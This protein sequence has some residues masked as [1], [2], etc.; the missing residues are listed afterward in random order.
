[1]KTD[2]QL[3]KEDLQTVYLESKDESG[4]ERSRVKR[5]WNRFSTGFKGDVRKFVKSFKIW[6]WPSYLWSD[7]VN[8]FKIMARTGTRQNKSLKIDMTRLVRAA[9]DGKFKT[10]KEYNNAIQAVM[11]KHNLRKQRMLD[12]KQFDIASNA[13]S[14]LESRRLKKAK[15]SG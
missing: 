10:G 12:H 13:T 9:A 6:L 4:N 1:M 14:I 3:L 11:K 5:F 7:T 15:G 2:K 8:A